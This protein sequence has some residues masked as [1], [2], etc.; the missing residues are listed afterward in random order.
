LAV[1]EF[2]ERTFNAAGTWTGGGEL[3]VTL[4]PGI[5]LY[6][7]D[8][9][10]LV[11]IKEV[12][13]DEV[14]VQGLDDTVRFRYGVEVYVVADR[15]TLYRPG[16]DYVVTPPGTITWLTTGRSP[17]LGEQYAVR[18]AAYPEY[19]VVPST[20]RLRV[21][22]QTQQSQVVVIQRLDKVSEEF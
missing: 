13:A 15:T 21:E 1:R 19:L 16:D 10:R 9:V 7:R 5:R 17:G 3:Q 12:F 4:L 2:S 6:E 22:N 14:L 11:N 20:P 18:Y 8:K